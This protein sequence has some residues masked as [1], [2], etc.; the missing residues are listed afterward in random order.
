MK[1]FF[2]LGYYALV[3]ITI[4]LGAFLALLHFEL[5][6]GYEIR[7]VQSGSM[8]PAITTGSVVVVQERG[9]YKVGDVITF[10][11]S[12]PGSLPTTHRVV[13]DIIVNGEMAYVTKG[14][15]N[16]S[17]DIESVRRSEVRGAVL[18]SIPYLGYILDF[19]RQP[20]GFALIIG[21]PAF[22]IA[23]EEIGN[24]YATVKGRKEE[25]TEEK[26][27]ESDVSKNGQ[28]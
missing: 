22:L 9:R 24:I 21:V 3:T 27:D 20:L 4:L 8:A 13:S 16:E 28:N 11:D 12:S 10:G 26:A 7:I 1:A 25:E 2:T 23:F 19:A 5:L 14:D 15:A 17:E 18:F 6:S